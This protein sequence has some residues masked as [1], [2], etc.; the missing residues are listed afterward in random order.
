M[1]SS[2]GG[3]WHHPGV[4]VG[5]VSAQRIRLLSDHLTGA[6]LVTGAVLAGVLLVLP[7]L[8]VIL[9]SFVN[10]PLGYL[11]TFIAAAFAAANV[12]GGYAVTDRMLQM[13]RK[14]PVPAKP[15]EQEAGR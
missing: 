1:A 9:A 13:F 2:G 15:A 5:P 4:R 8:V 7:T 10:G 11:L 3:R 6:A 12:V 14:R